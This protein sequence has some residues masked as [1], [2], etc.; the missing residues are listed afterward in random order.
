MIELQ[1]FISEKDT[2]DTNSLRLV[3]L[4]SVSIAVFLFILDL[5]LEVW[6]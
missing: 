1:G 3:S 5:T 4:Q 6:D 2:K